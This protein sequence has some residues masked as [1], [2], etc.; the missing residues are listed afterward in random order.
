[1][2]VGYTDGMVAV[3]DIDTISDVLKCKDELE[4]ET[5]LPFKT[6]KAHTHYISGTFNQLKT[7]LYKIM[8]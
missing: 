8:F 5:V 6:I 4:V 2:A 3:F 7:F 1:M